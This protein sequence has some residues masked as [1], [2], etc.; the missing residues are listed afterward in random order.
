MSTGRLVG[1]TAIVTGAGRGIGRGIALGYA[2]EGAR[3]ALVSRNQAELEEV[4]NEIH[5]HGG[6]ALVTP[7]DVRDSA[8]VD[9]VV[10]K[11]VNN[12]GTVDALVNSAGIPMV[13]PTSELS[14]ERWQLALDI[15]L[16]GTFYFCRAVGAVMLQQGRA[17]TIVNIGSLHSFQGIPMRAAYA[18]SKGAVLQLTRSLATEWAP[19]GIRVNCISP[20]WIRTPL[21][22]ELVKQGKLDRAPIIARTPIK[23]VGEVSDIVGPAIFLAS[24]E[25]AFIVGEQLI[26]DGGWGVYGFI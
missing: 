12:W 1:R 18:A 4:A 20:G 25:S 7:A 17:G 11:V 24:D 9:A 10:A 15:N 6:E 8:A 19:S 22:D 16:N 2:N 21:Q 3:V 23:R 5:Q 13:S 26:V 14:D